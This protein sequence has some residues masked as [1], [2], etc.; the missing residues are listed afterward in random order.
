MQVEH[1]KDNKKFDYVKIVKT[2]FNFNAKHIRSNLIVSFMP[3]DIKQ[4][5]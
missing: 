3:H 5:I 2:R 1:Q 4:N